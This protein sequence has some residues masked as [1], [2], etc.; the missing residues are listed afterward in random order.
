MA[1]FG[2]KG[3]ISGAGMHVSFSPGSHT[4]ASATHQ[5]QFTATHPPTPHIPTITTVIGVDL[6][7]TFSVA[8]INEH[9]T[10]RVI[11]DTSGDPLVPSVVSFLPKA[12][13]RADTV[14]PHR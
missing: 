5:Q 2:F 11:N 14:T 9:G 12:S 4:A 10:V 7:T 8:A 1:A 6:G 13:K 3:R